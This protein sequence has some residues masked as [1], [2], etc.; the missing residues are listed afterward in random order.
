LA[1]TSGK[2]EEQTGLENILTVVKYDFGPVIATRRFTR[3]SVSSPKRAASDKENATDGNVSDLN[4]NG[5]G[6]PLF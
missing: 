5:I 1:I 4:V 3:R 2:D 6:Q